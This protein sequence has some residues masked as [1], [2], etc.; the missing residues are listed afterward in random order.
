MILSDRSDAFP[1]VEYL[2]SSSHESRERPYIL[3]GLVF[4]AVPVTFA[5]MAMA[6]DISSGSGL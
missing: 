4:M 1:I 6:A 2:I 5:A 3:E